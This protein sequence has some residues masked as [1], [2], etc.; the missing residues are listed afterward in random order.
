MTIDLLKLKRKNIPYT[1]LYER[2]N[3]G[4]STFQMRIVLSVSS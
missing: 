1:S 4:Y 3:L 2:V